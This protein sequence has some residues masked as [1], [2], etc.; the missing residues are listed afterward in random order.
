MGS[1]SEDS[2]APSPT[3]STAGETASGYFS[4]GAPQEIV[5]RNTKITLA[6]R[7]AAGGT[8]FSE[9]Q[10]QM[11]SIARALLKRSSI[12][13]LD[14]GTHSI[15]PA[16]AMKIRQTIREEFV[17]SLLITG[18]LPGFLPRCESAHHSSSGSPFEYNH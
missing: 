15:D 3:Y 8:N 11:I 10:R 13:I 4:P 12:V 18:K 5:G 7:V 16:T 17:G 6:T 1:A 9:G 2:V 14:E